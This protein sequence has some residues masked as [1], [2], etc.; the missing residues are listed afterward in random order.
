MV[1]PST[2]IAGRTF[3]LFDVG[4]VIAITVML[5]MAISTACHHIAVLYR[6]EKLDAEVGGV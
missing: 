2:R 5:G 4:G 1:D 3:L 6:E